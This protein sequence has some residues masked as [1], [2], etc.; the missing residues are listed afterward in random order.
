MNGFLGHEVSEVGR[1]LPEM[2]EFREIKPEK[3]MRIDEARSYWDDFFSGENLDDTENHEIQQETTESNAEFPKTEVVD[4]KKHYYDDAGNLYRIDNEL[5]PNNSYELNGYTYTTD[6]LGRIVS[7]EGELHL[8]DREGKLR[9]KDSMDDIGKGDQREGDDRGHLIG[10]QF[11]GTNGL[12]NMVPQDAEIN[13]KD[14]KYFENQLAKEVKDG[15]SVTVKVEP[16]YE[17]DSRRP[18]A[19]VV[20]YSIDGKEDV[21][22]FPNSSKEDYDG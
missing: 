20:S 8:K 12:E 14:F 19:I 10:D 4:G 22:V 9:I 13:Q 17:G 11:D 16:V 1:N 5:L 21:R 2:N 18:I 3:D 6:G 7:A 15:K